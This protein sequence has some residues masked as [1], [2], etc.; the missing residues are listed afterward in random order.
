MSISLKTFL[1]A[2]AIALVST[3]AASAAHAQTV[4]FTGT[5][6]NVNP[7]APPGSGRCAPTFFNTVTIAPGALSSTGTSNLG[8]F[9]S[10]QSHCIASPLPTTISDGRFTYTFRGGDSISGSYTGTA[11]TGSAAGIFNGTENLVVT[12]G[13]GRFVGS[14]GTLT[15]MGTLQI[16]NGNGVFAGTV[17]GPLT[18]TT[19]TASGDFATALG[20]PSAATGANSVALGAFSLASGINS[21][22]AGSFAEAIAADAT[23]VGNFTFASGPGSTALGKGASATAP[24]GSALGHN[25]IASGLASTAVGVRATASGVGAVS[26]GRLS[27]A[28]GDGATALGAGAMAGQSG[29]TAIGAGATT[30]AANQ[31]SLG[32]LGSSVRVGDIAASTA[33]QQSS[34]VSLATVDASGT[35]GRNTTLL[36]TVAALQAGQTAMT[37][38]VQALFEAATVNR[39]DVRRAYEGVAMAL[40]MESPHLPAG[41]RFGLSGGVGYYG[42]RMA[43]TAAFAARVGK[44]GAVSAGAGF[45]FN[46]GKVGLRAGFQHAW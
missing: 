8:N 18:A 39:R 16:V 4:N 22:A 30:S 43:G 34:T 6:E 23:A 10:T 29:S 19:T 21:L 7:L 25:S 41:T 20:V 40:A 37:T 2:S 3:L 46:S 11:T 28:T 17:V 38:Q 13:T 45:G 12:G 1:K 32:G 9:T 27:G 42:D 33:A 26:I 36:P 35:L 24:A 31:V 15:G 14:T 5:R 44:A